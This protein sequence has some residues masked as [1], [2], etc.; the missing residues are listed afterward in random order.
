MEDK[1]I[2]LSLMDREAVLG[3]KEFTV[4]DSNYVFMGDDRRVRADLRLRSTDGTGIQLATNNENEEALQ[5]I[6]LSINRLNLEKLFSVL[7]YMPEVSG[8]LNGDFHAIQTKDALSISSAVSVTDLA[9]Q[10]SQMGNLS[11]EFVTCRNPTADTT[12]DGTLS[13]NDIQDWSAVGYVQF[14]SWWAA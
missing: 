1:G 3:Y 13:Q 14:G 6:T 4:N 5:D 10:Q 8:T 11:S 2:Q 7:P 12:F 9:Y